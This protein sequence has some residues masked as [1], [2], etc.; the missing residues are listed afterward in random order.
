[1]GVQAVPSL[2]RP[3]LTTNENR[4]ESFQIEIKWKYEKKIMRN[5]NEN[6][7]GT[8]F[9][10]LKQNF[11]FRLISSFRFYG[12][13]GQSN[14]HDSQTFKAAHPKISDHVIPSC[15]WRGFYGLRFPQSSS[16][17]WSRHGVRVQV[18]SVVNVWFNASLGSS[19]HSH[20]S[21]RSHVFSLYMFLTI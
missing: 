2:A 14:I 3:H 9:S 13:Y 15:I 18:S 8:V 21:R 16:K 7:N 1:M 6:E 11:H 20:P 17:S 10:K 12:F 5:G 19:E 4:V